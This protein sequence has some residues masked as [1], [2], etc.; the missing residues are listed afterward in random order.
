M[1]RASQKKLCM[2]LAAGV[3]VSGT[4]RNEMIAITQQLLHGMHGQTGGCTS[5]VVEVQMAASISRLW[6]T[7]SISWLYDVSVPGYLQKNERGD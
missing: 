1:K 3:T 5:G 4:R 7:E 6:S 2:S